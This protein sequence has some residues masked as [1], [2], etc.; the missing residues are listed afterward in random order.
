M[1]KKEEDL[2]TIVSVQREILSNCCK[3]VKNGGI[4]FYS[5][6]TLNKAE[7]EENILWFLEEHP[8]FKLEPIYFGNVENVV[9]STNG[10]ITILPNETM[11]GFF[12]SKLRKTV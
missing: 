12:M 8:E 7:N 5:T 2:K 9:Y 6:C 3:Y 11:D 1:D 10:V 4:L